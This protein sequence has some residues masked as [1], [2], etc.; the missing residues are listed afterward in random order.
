VQIAKA[1]GAIVAATA[2]TDKVDFVRALGADEV[3]DYRKGNFVEF[4]RDID[5]ALET[6]GGDH[7]VDTLKVLRPGGTLISLLGV[8]EKAEAAA[9][10]RGVRIERISVRPDRDALLEL[11]KL[12]EDGRLK[13]HV[14]RTFPLAQAGDAH[15]LLG[16]KPKGKIVLTA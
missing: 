1:R 11:A 15:K 5:H 12:V 10:E 2:S 3:I 6:V 13:V 16:T 7:A 9:K 8:S 14:D 4:V